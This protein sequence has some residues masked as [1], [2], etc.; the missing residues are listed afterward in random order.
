MQCNFTYY[1]LTIWNCIQLKLLLFTAKLNRI[2][3]EL[4]TM[5]GMTDSSLLLGLLNSTGLFTVAT[6]FKA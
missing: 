1:I 4:D 5:Q 2:H 3:K 6:G